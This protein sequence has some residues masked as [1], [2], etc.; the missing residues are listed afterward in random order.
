MSSCRPHL[1][2]QQ[3]WLCA[4]PRGAGVWDQK[5]SGGAQWLSSGDQRVASSR[6]TRVTT[7]C[8]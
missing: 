6:L 7:L 4:R 1:S 8:P 3:I 5:L 2:S